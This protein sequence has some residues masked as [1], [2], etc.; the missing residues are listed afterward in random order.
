MADLVTSVRIPDLISKLKYGEF[1]VPQFQREFV[2]SI[3]DVIALLNSIIDARP[4]GM[5]TVWE[6]P[7]DSGLE[8]EHISVADTN[9]SGDEDVTFFG[10]PKARAT[11]TF[12]VLDGRQ[13]LTAI[14]M[15]FGGLRALN[16]KRKHSGKF[17]LNVT[18]SDQV[19][20]IIFK[21]SAEI[22]RE[23]L[24]SLATCISSGLFP[25]EF[26]DAAY[27]NMDRQWMDYV[28]SIV[29][30]KFYKNSI[31]PSEEELDRRSNALDNA[32]NGIIS[33]TLAVYSVPKQY[34]LGTICEIFETLN[35]TGTRVSTVDLIHSW[36]Y[37]E[38]QSESPKPIHLREWIKELGAYEGAQ[39][40][41]DPKER[42]ELIAQFVTATHVA[43]RSPSTPRMVGGKVVA[44]SSLKS[45]DLLA[46]PKEHWRDV[47]DKTEEFARYIG[48]FQRS[49]AEGF[50]P[51]SDCPYPISAAIYIALRW[52]NRVDARG[53]SVEAIDCLYRAFF[54]RNA[55]LGRYD[56][57]FLTKISVD[58]K[59]LIEL[60]ES[61]SGK[62]FG[63]W[64]QACNSSLDEHVG[65]IVEE[66]TLLA[67][68]LDAKPAGA[69]GK[70]L[71]LPVLV[72]ARRDL[73]DPTKS[74]SFEKASEAIDLHHI[75]PSA[76]IR[77]NVSE[78]DIKLWNQQGLGRGNCI[79][80]L[81]P[82]TR[83]S[84]LIW[85]AKVPGKALTD[86]HVT[87]TS[88]S[89]VFAQH[90]IDEPAYDCLVKSGAGLP[91]FWRLRAG[92]IAKWLGRQML[93]SS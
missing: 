55:L 80:N 70:A 79:A 31:L 64:I 32:F 51:M 10:D 86:A 7:D 73:L 24:G 50:F 56:Q 74:V 71:S 5:L 89:E 93:A 8:L 81:T 88:H 69:L 39:G 87:P 77:D 54:W 60:L 27:E 58:L 22:E 75:Y 67:Q 62:S 6:Q 15:A 85:R 46:T 28:K 76:W 45:G 91:E 11:K 2:W 25:F 9:S 14:S 38:T 1:L 63:E 26:D 59:M 30:P 17:F 66:Q 47:I 72:G 16:G 35:T 57:G 29:Q 4:I 44:I 48:D 34:D 12:A 49:V 37:A 19:D 78:A 33:T 92:N 82:M 52:T 83:K 42:P 53:W 21:K 3:A 41:A 43:E 20:R 13:R 90:F 65:A 84:N 36:L 68:L 23:N 18:A 61:N 40:W